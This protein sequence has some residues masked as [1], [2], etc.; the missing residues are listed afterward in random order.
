M[1]Q[2]HLQGRKGIAKVKN[3][4][5]ARYLK[6]NYDCSTNEA[7]NKCNT[8]FSCDFDRAIHFLYY[9]HDSR[10]FSRSKSQFQVQISKLTNQARNMCNTSF[11]CD[12]V[13]KI[14]LWCYFV[15]PR[16]FSRSKGHF[17]GQNVKIWCFRKKIGRS[18]IRL[19]DMFFDWIIYS[20]FDDKRSSLR[21]KCQFHGQVKENTIF[22]KYS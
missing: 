11:S 21:S 16:S 22:H 8:S 20:C 2:G 12:F 19:F 3:K 18:V 4:M 17:Q 1:I 6:V 14:H 13:W 15:D 5:A 9:F 10:S 7:R